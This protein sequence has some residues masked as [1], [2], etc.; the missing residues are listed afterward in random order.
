MIRISAALTALVF[1]VTACGSESKPPAGAATRP[2][3]HLMG[4]ANVP[5]K[6]QRV[7]VLW[8]PTLSAV[9][10]L[11]VRPVAAMGESN[12][13]DLGP[14]LPSGYK[15]DDLAIV[16]SAREI[17]FERLAAARPDL[18]LATKALVD[19]QASYDKLAQLAP[20]VVLNW[21]GTESWRTHVAEVA[22]ALD[23]RAKA[24]E[25]VKRY[26][27]RLT[28]VR[29]ALGAAAGKQVSLVRIQA[30]EE[31]RL[32]TPKSFAGQILAEVGFARPANQM[33]ADANR[34]YIALSLERIPEATGDAI[35]VM[36]NSTKTDAWK[37]ISSNPLWTQLP[38][39]KTNRVFTTDY[40]YWGASNYI[41][42]HRILDD[43]EKMAPNIKAG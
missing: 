40:D 7:A 17:N 43:L 30:A 20:T 26:Q 33:S 37:A 18:I 36:V 24:D 31:I 34:D 5:A 42:A 27:D 3:Q 39:A 12:A 32:E 15:T 23:A 14:Y 4:T 11:G 8:R 10:E 9:V 2:V 6:P 16:S 13:K 38:A 25:V 28:A 22:T 21:T 41:G 19:S 35:I 29:T 1:L